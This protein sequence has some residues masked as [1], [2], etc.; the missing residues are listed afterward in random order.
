MD[1]SQARKNL[2]RV[3]KTSS[4]RPGT[5]SGASSRKIERL[6]WY[7]SV[8][9]PCASGRAALDNSLKPRNARRINL[10]LSR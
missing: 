10:V 6:N 3:T 2:M 1:V 5:T 4:P 7:I 8:L 9:T